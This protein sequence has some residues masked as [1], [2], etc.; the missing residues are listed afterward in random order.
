MVDAVGLPPARILAVLTA[1]EM[2]GAVRRDPS[3]WIVASVPAMGS[4]GHGF[5]DLR[6]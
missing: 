6:D 5:R 1:L 4:R 2:E 3:G